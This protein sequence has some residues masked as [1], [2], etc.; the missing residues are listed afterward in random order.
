VKVSIRTSTSSTMNFEIR[1][2]NFEFE[3]KKGN[4]EDKK[5]KPIWSP[6]KR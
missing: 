5:M 1:I 4:L 6:E 2:S 3:S